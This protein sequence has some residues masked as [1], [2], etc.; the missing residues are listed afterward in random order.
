MS[1]NDQFLE[2]CKEGNLELVKLLIN[3][4][5]NKFNHGMAY[6][7]CGGYI[8]IVEFLISKG[9][10]DFNWGLVCACYKKNKNIIK[11]ML[12]KGVNEYC[13]ILSNACENGIKDL[14]ELMILK[15]ADNFD[16]GLIKACW[17][18]DIE[19]VKLMI[20]KGCNEWR[21][22]LN[23]ACKKG[24][25]EIVELIL[26]EG[27]ANDFKNNKGYDLDDGLF[28]SCRDGHKDI[29]LYMIIKGANIN[30]LFYGALTFEDIYYLLYHK[31]EKFGK[32]SDIA[33]ECEKWKLEF[34]NI[35]N[36]LFIKDVAN[37]VTEY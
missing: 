27:V 29:T 4:G 3:N 8:E 35:S 6:A 34:S 1:L 16:E 13:W 9:A 24:H 5:A 15:G 17:G 26:R 22:A 32:F 37:I 19:I 31:V 25:M 23:N 30:D 7:C 14:V 10:A 12:D 28:Y 36:E 33:N 21:E 11:L 2:A 20:S 18:G